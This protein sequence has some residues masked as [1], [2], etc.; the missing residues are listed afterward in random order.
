VSRL[1]GLDLGERRIGIAVADDRTG[2]VRPLATISRARDVEHDARTIAR[3]ATE[4]RATELVVGLPLSLDGSVGPQARTTTEWAERIA[5]LT[6]LPVSMR[7][8]RLTT[9]RAKTRVGNASRGRSGGPPGERRRRAHNARL[10]REA[11]TL[12]LQ[13]ELDERANLGS[14]SGGASGLPTA[15]HESIP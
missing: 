7:D 3:L 10:D 15:P 8:E 2:S 9:E 11:A 14:P 13:A 12:I 4:Q 6:G 5:A 1:L